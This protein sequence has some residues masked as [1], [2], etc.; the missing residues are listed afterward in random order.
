MQGQKTLR[1]VETIVD[2][3]KWTHYEE[4]K[5]NIFGY[6]RHASLNF[7]KKRRDYEKK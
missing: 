7:L 5:F 3:K 4:T 6:L 1:I 2:P